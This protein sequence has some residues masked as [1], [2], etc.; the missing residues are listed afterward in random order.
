MRAMTLIAIILEK[1]ILGAIG[2]LFVAGSDTT[3]NT[4]TWAVLYLTTFQQVQKD[5][6]KEIEEKVGNSRTVSLTDKPK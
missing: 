4:L 2:D 5:F 1:R 6:Q 3:S